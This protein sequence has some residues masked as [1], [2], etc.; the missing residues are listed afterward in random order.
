MDNY[1]KLPEWLKLSPNSPVLDQFLEGICWPLNNLTS[2]Y[3]VH[4]RLVQSLDHARVHRQ[5]YSGRCCQSV[6]KLFVYFFSLANFSINTN[7][8]TIMSVL[9][10]IRHIRVPF[11]IHRCTCPSGVRWISTT[12]NLA[13]T[14]SSMNI[15]D[16]NVKRMHRERAAK[17][18]LRHSQYLPHTNHIPF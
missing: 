11:F 9:T 8:P 4:H 10:G 18:W 1:M 13:Q 17:R 3:P 2:S 12:E 5:I 15:F 7:I 6:V 14:Q 16:R